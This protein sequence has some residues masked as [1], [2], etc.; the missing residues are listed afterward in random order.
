[1][2]SREG[3][4]ATCGSPGAA[5]P[6]RRLGARRG[7]PA[8]RRATPGERG[9]RG[10]GRAGCRR[11]PEA[12]RLKPDY[13]PEF[14]LTTAYVGRPLAIGGRRGGRPAPSGGHRHGGA[15][16]RMRALRHRGGGDGRPTSPRSCATA[17]AAASV[18]GTPHVRH[19][20]RRSGAGG[21]GRASRPG[22][23][24]AATASCG[25]PRPGLG[26]HPDP[27]PRRA[28]APAHVRGLHRRHHRRGGQRRARSDRQRVVR[29]RDPHPGRSGWPITP[30]CASCATRGPSIGP[31][32]NNAGAGRPGATS[33]CSSTTTSRRSAAGWLAALCAQA[34]RPDVG[35]GRS[36]A[37]VPRPPPAALRPGRRAHGGGR[38][39]P[40]RPGRDEPGYLHMA[41]G[42]AN[43][44][45]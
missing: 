28:T 9:L 1:M 20:R 34:L 3:L 4:D 37:P 16:A 12:P 32:L 25:P 18:P 36:P 15:R 19:I 30:T 8:E 23:D 29:P 11:H 13:S 10:R 21:T 42:P 33:C 2:T 17:G 6:R 27:V 35:G 43:A 39:R 41:T 24:Q 38:A 31:A 14:L 22:P 5:L 40:R 26:E 7:G 45:R 44:R